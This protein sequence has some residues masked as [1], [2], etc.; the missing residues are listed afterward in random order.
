M[1]RITQTLRALSLATL[2]AVGAA[3]CEPSYTEYDIRYVVGVTPGDDVDIVYNGFF[4]RHP[5][6]K[7]ITKESEVTATLNGANG[8]FPCKVTATV[9]GGQPPRYLRIEVSTDG[10]AYD[11]MAEGG[12]GATTVSWTTPLD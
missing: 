11:I 2:M 9:N 1:S 7:G 5:E 12:P 10:G 6:I 8:G 4:N 3:S